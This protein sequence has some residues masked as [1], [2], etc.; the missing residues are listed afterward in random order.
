M[1]IFGGSKK[2][3]LILKENEALLKEIAKLKQMFD[4][5]ASENDSLQSEKNQL[6]SEINKL[7]ESPAS[8]VGDDHFLSDFESENLRSEKERLVLELEAVKSQL[9]ENQ[10]LLHELNERI[11]QKIKLVNLPDNEFISEAASLRQPQEVDYTES[12][13]RAAELEE[14]IRQMNDQYN[15]TQESLL[16]L[17]SVVGELSN[18]KEALENEIMRLR[19]YRDQ[20]AAGYQTSET[21]FSSGEDEIASRIEAL[22]T[23]LLTKQ[24]E[25][26]VFTE[27]FQ[28]TQKESLSTIFELQKAIDE[29]E[30]KLAELNNKIEQHSKD[31]IR[32]DIVTPADDSQAELLVQQNEFLRIRISELEEKLFSLEKNQTTPEYDETM[33]FEPEVQNELI[34]ENTLLKERIAGL[35]NQ[36]EN[37]RQN[38]MLE[39]DSVPEGNYPEL[40]QENEELKLR[41]YEL[42]S[43]IE[44]LAF[45]DQRPEVVS[46]ET[47]K[48]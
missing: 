46:D 4:K 9:N 40:Q 25:L 16:E 12:E 38:M 47:V 3:D 6:L 41:I 26:Q 10:E 11:D 17:K 31:D 35:E 42:E 45:V 18:E 44:N 27:S 39:H 1:A 22:N 8:G 48:L 33:N 28:K 13:S 15:S 43:R 36:I 23:E 2:N 20:E 30:A 24:D 19:E 29:A 5:L 7:R 32:F 37:L 21:A 34:Q 14:L